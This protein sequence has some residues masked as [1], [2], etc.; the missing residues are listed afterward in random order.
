MRGYWD[1]HV[2]DVDCGSNG[3][4]CHRGR[5][6]YD[7]AAVV[8]ADGT[9]RCWGGNAYGQCDV[10]SYIGLPGREAVSV[11]PGRSRR[12]RGLATAR[13]SCGAGDLSKGEGA[14]DAITNAR[15]SLQSLALTGSSFGAIIDVY[16]AYPEDLN[17]DGVVEGSDLG[18]FFSEWG[19]CWQPQ[20]CSAGLNLD[21]VVDGIDVGY[22]S[23]RGEGAECG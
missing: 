9:I 5:G 20:G 3:G 11:A 21:G 12:W 22:F 19:T 16:G 7:H 6:G 8:L 18:L 23:S 4:S 1:P 13:W 2:P 10:P 17:G 14:P 15:S